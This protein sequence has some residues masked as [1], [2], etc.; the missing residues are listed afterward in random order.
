MA[1]ALAHQITR[2]KGNIRL[3]GQDISRLR[4]GSLA[5]VMAYAGPEPVLF[6]STIRD[7]VVYSLRRRPPELPGA[8]PAQGGGAATP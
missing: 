5:R 3:N 2:W 6:P 4:S 8:A 7:N 1:R